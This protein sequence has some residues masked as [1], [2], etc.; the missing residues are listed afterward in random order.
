MKPTD[1]GANSGERTGT[2]VVE[3]ECTCHPDDNPPWPCPR[4]Y[5]LSECRA[6]E[7]SYIETCIANICEALK[8]PMPNLERALLVADR[9]DLRMRL[10][11]ID[12]MRTTPPN[13]REAHGS[14]QRSSEKDNG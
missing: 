9:K 12:M 10:L 7:R 3:R 1:D 6:A 13:P 14:G 2:A 5:A 8:G 11:T 4:K